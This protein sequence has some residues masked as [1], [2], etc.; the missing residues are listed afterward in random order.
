MIARGEL[1]TINIGKRRLVLVESYRKRIEELKGKPPQDARRNSV[2]PAIGTKRS[3]PAA[4][5]VSDQEPP[6]K[7]GSGRPR[8]NGAAA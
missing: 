5:P 3:A 6:P 8:K 4:P 1:E 2:V 7:R